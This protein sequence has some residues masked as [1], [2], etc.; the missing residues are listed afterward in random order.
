MHVQAVSRVKFIMNNLSVSNCE[1]KKSELDG[2]LSDEHWPWFADYLV[3]TRAAQEPNFHDLYLQLLQMLDRKR[4]WDLLTT[5]T[6]KYIRI[7]LESERVK[8]VAGERSL[9]RNL[10]S[11]LGRLTIQRNKMVLFRQLDL[12]SILY[13][14]T[15]SQVF[16]LQ[17]LHH[18][19]NLHVTVSYPAITST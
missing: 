15:C 11:W 5:I 3:V 14:V 18:S 7:L 6:Y 17:E 4:V 2:V 12:K 16:L 10:G 13:Q 1:H 19:S 8:T 9:L